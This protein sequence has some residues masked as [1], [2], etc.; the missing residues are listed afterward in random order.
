MRDPLDACLTELASTPVAISEVVLNV[1]RGQ[2]NPEEG[3]FAPGVR[4]SQTTSPAMAKVVVG[5]N[6]TML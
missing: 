1:D 3:V 6:Q 4:A 2:Y 5:P